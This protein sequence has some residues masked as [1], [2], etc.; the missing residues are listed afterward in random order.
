[1]Y[2]YTGLIVVLTLGL[3]LIFMKKGE[4]SN[5]APDGSEIEPLTKGEQ[6]LRGLDLTIEAIRG[7]IQSTRPA[8]VEIEQPEYVG[9]LPDNSKMMRY[10]DPKG[11]SAFTAK[12]AKER[13]IFNHIE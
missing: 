4:K 7:K 8:P 5:M 3:A 6:L 12:L 10:E 9:K 13:G 2:K 1:M 11:T